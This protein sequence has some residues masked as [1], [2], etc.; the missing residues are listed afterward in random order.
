MPINEPWP[1]SSIISELHRT[2]VTAD[3][4]NIHG[5]LAH[6]VKVGLAYETTLN[7]YQR[8]MTRPGRINLVEAKKF[9][10]ITVQPKP[11]QGTAM[12]EAMNRAKPTQKKSAVDMLAQVAADLRN[13]A[14][15]LEAEADRLDEIALQIA[16]E[17]QA[18]SKELA[19]IARVRAA[20]KTLMGD[21]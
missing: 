20:M 3:K 15:D 8:A 14:K 11:E 4:S 16:E 13:Q 9:V 18:G 17:Q 2:G 12:Q 7:H 1:L 6:M 5:C 10:P 19:E 21:S